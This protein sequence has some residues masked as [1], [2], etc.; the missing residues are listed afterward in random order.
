MR[1]GFAFVSHTSVEPYSELV[2]GVQAPAKPLAVFLAHHDMLLHRTLQQL[3]FHR[4]LEVRELV[5]SSGTLTAVPVAE[6]E[7]A[8]TNAAILVISPCRHSMVEDTEIFTNEQR[9]VE[10]AAAQR[11]RIAIFLQQ[12]DCDYP[13]YMT[14]QASAYV[15]LTASFDQQR[16]DL[17][18][19]YPL[20]NHCNLHE[21]PSNR[22]SGHYFHDNQERAL[23]FPDNVENFARQLAKLAAPKRP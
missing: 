23:H 6:I 5:R 21:I 1:K 8:M 19:H 22:R 10:L 4:L 13:P 7:A 20:A 16:A 15:S 2:M 18:K 17:R 11:K 3:S 12:Q 9:A 14:D